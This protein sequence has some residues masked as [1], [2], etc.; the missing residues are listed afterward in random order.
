MSI[1]ITISDEVA[2]VL[3]SG[4]E[5]RE[6]RARESIALELYREGRINLRAMGR[7]AGVGDYY[8]AA[9]AFR[10]RFGVP[11]VDGVPEGADEQLDGMDRLIQA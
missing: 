11:L 7:L 6:R 3:G 10:T 8:W 5:E 9:D 1:T 4:P 2:C